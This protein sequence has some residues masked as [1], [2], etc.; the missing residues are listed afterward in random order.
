MQEGVYLIP[1]TALLLSA[2]LP[3]GV[4]LVSNNFHVIPENLYPIYEKCLNYKENKEFS[5]CMCWHL[6][7]IDIVKSKG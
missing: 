6:F 5:Y 7:N 1:C 4:R 2:I 3:K